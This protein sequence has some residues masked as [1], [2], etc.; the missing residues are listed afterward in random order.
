MTIKDGGLE[1]FVV[2]FIKKQMKLTSQP[3]VQ[4][5]LIVRLFELREEV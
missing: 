4:M 5:A 2:E 3:R 1:Q